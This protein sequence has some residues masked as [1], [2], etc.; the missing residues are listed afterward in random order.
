MREILLKTSLCESNIYIG[1]DSLKR[2]PA[3]TQGQNNFVVTDETVYALYPQFFDEYFKDIPLFV[4]PTGEE[5]KNFQILSQILEKMLESGLGR[6]SRLFAVG[7]G[8]VG[9]IGGLASALFARGISCVQIPTTLLAQIDSS[10]G[11]KTAVNHGGVKNSVGV[12][13][14]PME[15]L[16]DPDFLKTLPPCERKCGLGELV[17]YAGL[18]GEIYRS[19]LQNETRFTD[20][21]LDYFT[22]LISLCVQHKAKVVASDEK[23]GG[24]RKSL[25]LGHTTGHAIE[26]V[27]G[28]S[29]GESVLYGLA[30]ETL[31]AMGKGVCEKSYGQSLL[32]VVKKALTIKP[33]K[34]VDFG[35]VEAFAIKAKS[36]KKNQDDGKITLVVAKDEGEWALLSLSYEEYC[37]ALRVAV[38]EIR[39]LED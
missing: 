5:N 38:A 35:D 24:L 32:S 19:L 25:N 6:N 4:M 26:L 9:D 8:V 11:G 2:I 16:I 33:F 3:L 13:Y 10:V 14:Q 36:D 37:D 39:N 17:K 31:I 30:L 29:H 23:E 21:E 28:L 12:F 27:F 22:D 1:R 15:V 34:K 20:L 18:N 7:G